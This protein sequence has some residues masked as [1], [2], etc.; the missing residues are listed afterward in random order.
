MMIDRLREYL[1][2]EPFQPF[3][4]LTTSG[5]GYEA[6]TPHSVAIAESYLFTVSPILIA[7]LTS[8]SIKLWPS[9]RFRPPPE[10]A[11]DNALRDNAGL[12]APAAL[13]PFHFISKSPFP[14]FFNDSLAR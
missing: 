4:I 11:F 13:Q 1:D 12:Q 14:Q 10:N 8:A 9:K 5:T 3:R 6:Q 7:R 2:R